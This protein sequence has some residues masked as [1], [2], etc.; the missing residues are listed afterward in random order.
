MAQHRG[1]QGV[2][3]VVG[4][5]GESHKAFL[6]TVAG[7]S[8]SGSAEL[9][10]LPPDCAKWRS[11]RLISRCRYGNRHVCSL[12]KDKGVQFVGQWAATSRSL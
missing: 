11:V 2:W 7:N 8:I 3:G 4:I 12:E 10:F 1:P 9:L 6:P 5:T